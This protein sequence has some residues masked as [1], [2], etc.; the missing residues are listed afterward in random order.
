[1]TEE[2][3]AQLLR[4]QLDNKTLVAQANVVLSTAWD[5]D[6]TDTQVISMYFCLYILCIICIRVF[7]VKPSLCTFEPVSLTL[8]S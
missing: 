3:A 5:E 8:R 7:T 2:E 1:M 6:F 4:S